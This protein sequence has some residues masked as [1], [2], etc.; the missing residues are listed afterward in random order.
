M[1]GK[2]IAKLSVCSQRQ[3]VVA[4]AT[5]RAAGFQKALASREPGEEFTGSGDRA[6]AK[7][8]G[9]AGADFAVAGQ[10]MKDEQA[11]HGEAGMGV[12]QLDELR[13]RILW[14]NT[15]TVTLWPA[16]W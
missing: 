15:V 5:R 8:G 6:L 1:V 4:A 11:V 3:P 13:A 9:L 2:G 7:I 12:H 16:L 10:M 14:P